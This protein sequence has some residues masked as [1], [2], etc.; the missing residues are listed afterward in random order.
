M[1]VVGWWL[2]GSPL[3]LM[4]CC[5]WAVVDVGE[6]KLSDKGEIKKKRIKE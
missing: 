3:L 4:F 1:V 6:E 5:C 2:G